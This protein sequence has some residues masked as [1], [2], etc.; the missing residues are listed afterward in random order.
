MVCAGDALAWLDE[1][2]A[3][4]QAADWGRRAVEVLQAGG[5]APP[6]G[7]LRRTGEACVRI[8]EVAAARGLYA[9]ALEQIEKNAVAGGSVDALEHAALATAQA[10]L[11][12]ESGEPDSALPLFEQAQELASEREDEHSVAVVT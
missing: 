4:R 1:R 12:V 7:L 5:R 11:L 3:Y 6:L 9:Q 2:F 10:R 8:G